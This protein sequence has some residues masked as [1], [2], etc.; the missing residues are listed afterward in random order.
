MKYSSVWISFRAP[1]LIVSSFDNFS[2]CHA[3]C[4]VQAGLGCAVHCLAF[5]TIGCVLFSTAL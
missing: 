2:V 1:I 3:L 5:T 4:G